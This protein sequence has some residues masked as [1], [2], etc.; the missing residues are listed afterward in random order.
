MSLIIRL[1]LVGRVGGLHNKL[2][3]SQI[4]SLGEQQRLQFARILLKYGPSRWFSVRGPLVWVS[5]AG[6]GGLEVSSLSSN[7]PPATAHD[8]LQWLFMASLCG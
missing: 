1:L 4:F 3:F 6:F 7:D 8:P 2:D 5:G